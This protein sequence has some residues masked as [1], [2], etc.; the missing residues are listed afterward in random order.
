MNSQFQLIARNILL[1]ES[2]PAKLS[3]RSVIHPMFCL[4]LLV[5]YEVDFEWY[6]FELVNHSTI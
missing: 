5:Y 3:H 1:A 2:T 6:D 4:L